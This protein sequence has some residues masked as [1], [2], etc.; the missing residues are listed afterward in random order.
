MEVDKL[1]EQAKKKLHDLDLIVDP[2]DLSFVWV[3]SKVCKLIGYS[4]KEAL[5]TQ[6]IEVHTGQEEEVKRMEMEFSCPFPEKQMN[7]PIR[8]KDGIELKLTT[9]TVCFE[10]DGQPYVIGK[11]LE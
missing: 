4:E 7:L 10:F 11:I 1:L 3:S 2:Y 5:A 9:K 8:T 6:M